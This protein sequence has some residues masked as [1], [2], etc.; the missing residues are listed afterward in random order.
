MIPLCSDDTLD[1]ADPDGSGVIFHLKYLTEK[2][3]ASR[4]FKLVNTAKSS[5]HSNG[6]D[7]DSE[8]IDLFVCG[9]SGTKTLFPENKMPSCCFRAADRSRLADLIAGKF[10]ELTGL[11]VAESKN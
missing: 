10:H 8:I 4:F 6:W 3:A 11:G 2:D 5:E 9:W 7:Y 1:V